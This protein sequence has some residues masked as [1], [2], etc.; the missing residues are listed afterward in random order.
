MQALRGN[1]KVLW[2]G[3]QA[4]LPPVG[5]AESPVWARVVHQARLTEVI[6]QGR[7]SGVLALSMR[8]RDRL[9][10]GQ[11]ITW[12]DVAEMADDAE[13][14]AT[15]RGGTSTVASAVVSAMRA[16]CDAIGVAWTNAAV[17]A[18]NRQAR[19]MLRQGDQRP[20]VP[21]DR[22]VFGRPYEW[23]DGDG[24]ARRTNSATVGTI[25]SVSDAETDHRG[26]VACT[27]CVDVD[28][29]RIHVQAPMDKDAHLAVVDG[30]K[31]RQAYYYGR[32]ARGKDEFTHARNMHYAMRDHYA[33][34]RDIY[35][36][37]AHKAQGSTVD[38]AVI[39]WDDCARNPDAA[40]AARLLYVAVT[41]PRS[42]LV[43]V[44]EDG[45]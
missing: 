43:F 45:A 14:M 15:I 39:H 29:T 7:D 28:G 40:E 19:A 33:D 17:T 8:I 18:I 32:G 44:H 13:D 6:R 2:V 38:V 34:L 30:W 16:G 3:D 37:T 4:Q 27:V 35:A 21:G 42:Y 10:R 31:R 25:V 26:V 22:V 41:R 36:S 5:E 23:T 24:T 11:R 9:E 1:A 20:Y 12:A